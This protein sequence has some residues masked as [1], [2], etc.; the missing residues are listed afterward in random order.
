MILI[1]QPDGVTRCVH[2]DKIPLREIG[3][4][5]TRRASNVE[6][7]ETDQR[8]EVRW[9]GSEEVVF[10]HPSRLVCLSWEVEQL[11]KNL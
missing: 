7:N 9:A 11:E 8:W 3:T 2:T 1:I 4:I 10:S 6:F 5:K